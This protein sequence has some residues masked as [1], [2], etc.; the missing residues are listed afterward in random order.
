M[1]DDR[2][3]FLQAC[4]LCGSPATLA[5]YYFVARLAVTRIHRP[6]DNRL[7][8]AL[9]LNGIRKLLQ[10]LSPHVHARLKLTALKKI[11][12]DVTELALVG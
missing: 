9:R 10:R 1:P 11:D 2:R 4:K 3:D 6:D 8:N 7:N 5:G 12:R